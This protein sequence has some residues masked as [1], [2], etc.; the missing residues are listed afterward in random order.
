MSKTLEKYLFRMNVGDIMDLHSAYGLPPHD[1]KPEMVSDLVRHVE[2]YK[3]KKMQAT[4]SS[5]AGFFILGMNDPATEQ[6]EDGDSIEQHRI[7]ATDDG[8]DDKDPAHAFIIQV[9]TIT[10]SVELQLMWASDDIIKLRDIVASKAGVPVDNIQLEMFDGT[11]LEDG[12]KIM[13]YDIEP[14]DIV[15]SVFV[16]PTSDADGEDGDADTL[17]DEEAPPSKT[18]AVLHVA[19][20]PFCSGRRDH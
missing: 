15:K 4:G 13:D 1:T 5:G 8:K 3:T 6:T 20:V 16:E 9:R 17:T 10:G 12:R 14:N 19:M 11:V 2:K 18:G 7:L